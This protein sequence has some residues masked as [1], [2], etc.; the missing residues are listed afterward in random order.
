MFLVPLSRE[1]RQFS[2]QYSRQYSR[3]FDDTFERFLAPVAAAEG[4]AARNPALDVAETDQGYTVKLGL[5][6][7]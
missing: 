6:A 4:V 7:R 5:Y 1:S 3:L 2:H